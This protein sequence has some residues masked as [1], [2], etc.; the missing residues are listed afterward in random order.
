MS[1]V[2]AIRKALQQFD[3]E[4]VQRPA[5]IMLKSRTFEM[6]RKEMTGDVALGFK[7]LKGTDYNVKD[8][9]VTIDGVLVAD[10]DA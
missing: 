9:T 6:I 10:E 8:D 3:A 4:D 5:I 1:V 2:A 7:D